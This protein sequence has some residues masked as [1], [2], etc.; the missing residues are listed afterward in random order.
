MSYIR[1]PPDGAGK[2]VYTQAHTGLNGG[3]DDVEAQVMHIADPTSPTQ[4]QKVDQYG[5]S[6]ISFAEGPPTLAGF[7]AL[8]V[9]VK[10]L[11]GSYMATSRNNHKDFSQT[12][13]N[14][15]Y[16][17]HD[18]TAKAHILGT[19]TTSGS[20]VTRTTNHYHPYI[21]GSASLVLLSLGC[22]D[23]GTTNNTRR[24]GAFDDNDGVY[25]ELKDTTLC[26]VIRSS[27]TGS[28]VETTVSQSNWN[29]DKLDGTG[30]SG[31]TIDV[32]KLSVYWID[33]QWLGAGRVRFG[34]YSSTGQRVVCHAFENANLSSVPYMRTGTLPIR[35]E[36]VNTG[37]TAQGTTLR[38]VCTAAYTE[39]N[40]DDVVYDRS[41]DM[42]VPWLS[43]GTGESPVAAL[44][45]KLSVTGSPHNSAS[46]FL[47]AINVYADGP[48]KITLYDRV[49][50]VTGTWVDANTDSALE[51]S[52]LPTLSGLDNPFG[53]IY[54]MSGTE[55]Y[56]LSDIFKPNDR[57]IRLNADGTESVWAITT[58][59]LGDT[60]GFN[61][62]M[63]MI[64]KELW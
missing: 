57:A 41:A 27:T 64:H 35:T 55:V 26:T 58:E 51:V 59:P 4:I 50:F 52:L 40:F 48:C 46:S 33:Y 34:V 63:D 49:T 45:S 9:S 24:W 53:V 61:M 37:L 13:V 15:G 19:T 22:G 6:S 47:D 32:S 11:L 62:Q 18:Y 8:N 31:E 43:Y 2:K 23:T 30:L 1:V 44:R 14:G 12:L 5:A 10:H 28:V 42:Y 29:G 3:A 21:P 16:I 7:G 38:E 17:T 36:N 60:T 25:F 20:R 54:A 56:N 39:A